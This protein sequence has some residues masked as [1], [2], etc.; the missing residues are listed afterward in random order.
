MSYR[1]IEP[2]K[3]VIDFNQLKHTPYMDSERKMSIISQQTAQKKN[4]TQSSNKNDPKPQSSF[5]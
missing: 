4:D 2:P 5:K 1:N 3:L